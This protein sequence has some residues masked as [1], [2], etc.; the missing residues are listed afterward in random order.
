MREEAQALLSE[1]GSIALIKVENVSWEQVS[2]INL[3][4]Y[5]AELKNLTKLDAFSQYFIF[6]IT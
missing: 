2:V 4:C 5:M 3:D 1:V 6:Y